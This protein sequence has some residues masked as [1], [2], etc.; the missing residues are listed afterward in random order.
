MLWLILE[1]LLALSVIIG[2]MW[3][4]LHTRTDHS[5]DDSDPAGQHKRPPT[6]G[7]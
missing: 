2:I 6:D 4:T 5:V 3:W 7:P 1:M